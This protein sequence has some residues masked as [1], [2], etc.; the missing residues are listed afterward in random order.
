MTTKTVASCG[1]SICDFVWNGKNFVCIVKEYD[2]GTVDECG[3][4]L[5]ETEMLD[6]RH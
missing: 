1:H 5:S 3:I 6:L 2:K 4:I